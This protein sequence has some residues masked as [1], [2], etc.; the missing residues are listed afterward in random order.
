M[1]KVDSLAAAM[2]AGDYL[3]SPVGRFVTGQNHV[4]SCESPTFCGAVLRGMSLATVDMIECR[5]GLRIGRLELRY[6]RHVMAR[7]H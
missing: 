2:T 6:Q 7:Q 4:V 5:S 1:R 3:A